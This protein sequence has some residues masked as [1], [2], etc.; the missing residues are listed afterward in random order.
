MI[1]TTFSI[2]GLSLVSTLALASDPLHGSK[3]KTIDDETKKPLSIVQFTE[4]SQGVLSAKI[5][6]V[7]E[8]TEGEK[9]TKCKGKFYNKPLKGVQIV[10]G[11]KKATHNSYDG[12]K[13]TDPKNGKTYSFNA[14]LSPDGK[15]LSGRGYI[16]ISALGRSQTWLRIN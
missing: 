5:I 7:L 3:W 1:K 8:G 2:L 13:I 4:N 9:C 6:H 10:S 12:G 15:T 14:K 11:L 16:G